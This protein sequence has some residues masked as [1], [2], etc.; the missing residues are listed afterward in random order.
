MSNLHKPLIAIIGPSGS[1]KSS[2][3]RKL[4]TGEAN[5]PYQPEEVL[6]YDIERKGLP[7]KPKFAVKPIDSF[8]QFQTQWAIDKVNPKYK[9]AV[10]DSGT[11]L[12][13]LAKAKADSAF[14]GYD[15]YKNYGTWVGKVLENAKNTNMPVVMTGID[16]IVKIP[17]AEGGE[18]AQRRFKI[19]GKQWEGNIEKEFLCVLFTEP[20]KNKTTGKMEYFFQT[21]TDGITSAKTP[22]DLFAEQLIPND[23]S[24][25]LKKVEEYLA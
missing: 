20:V 9:L 21:N 6:F 5:S 8:E 19:E 15:I 25:V 22:I 17:L 3:L 1:G 24:L 4:V 18:R 10:W 14:K 7:F 23:I 12:F 2:S 11:K 13:E 16:E